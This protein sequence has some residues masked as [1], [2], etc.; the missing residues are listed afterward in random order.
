MSDEAQQPKVDPLSDQ[1]AEG[2]L[3]FLRT[4]GRAAGEARAHVVYMEKYVKVVL[5][6]LKRE[7]NDPLAKSDAARTDWA[8][9][10]PEYM[11]VLQA[12]EEAIVALTEFEWKRTAAEATIEAWR[13]NSANQRGQGKMQ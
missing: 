13:T 3:I 8:L 1:S 4:Q 2:A 9:T 10:H 12:Q 6:R 5:A 11:A 7:C